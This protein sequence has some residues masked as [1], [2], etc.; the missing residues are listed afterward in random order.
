MNWLNLSLSDLRR[1]EFLA[2]DLR[3]RGAWLSLNAWCAEVENGGR[4]VAARSWGA[5]MWA[6]ICGVKASEITKSSGLW[7]WDGDDLVVWN[8]PIEKETEVQ[9]KRQNGKK[10]GRPSKDEV[11]GNHVVSG[12]D[13]TNEPDG[14]QGRKRKGI[15]KE[16]EGNGSG[17]GT[18]QPPPVEFPSGFP[19]SLDQAVAWVRGLAVP[20]AQEMAAEF[21]EER[22]RAVIGQ[23][24]KAGNGTKVTNWGPWMVSQWQKFGAEWLTKRKAQ[25][26][27]GTS[28]AAKKKLAAADDAPDGW[29][30]GADALFDG[31]QW[32][33]LGGGW[34]SF[35]TKD[36]EWIR[37]WVEEKKNN[38]ISQ[39]EGETQ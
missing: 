19:V 26:S 2:A 37:R 28:G 5:E 8:Y 14:K 15:G 31:T 10:G 11:N 33:E 20:A 21:I 39:P 9:V 16:R 38:R 22:W 25:F 7:S 35:S 3:Q 6:R 24:F 23:G 12:A 32:R 27:G 1:P 36:R 29:E 13:T 18:E 30:A 17:N 34:D 4:I